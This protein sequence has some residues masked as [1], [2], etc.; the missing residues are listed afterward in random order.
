MKRIARRI[1]GAVSGLVVGYIAAF[2]VF[3]FVTELRP[4]EYHSLLRGSLYSSLGFVAGTALA[5]SLILPPRR[6]WPSILMGLL[7]YNIG[8]LVL[9]ALHLGP[10]YLHL[11]TRLIDFEALIVGLLFVPQVLATVAFHSYYTPHPQWMPS[12]LS[13]FPC[14]DDA[15][16]ALENRNRPGPSSK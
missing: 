15:A 2:I 7:C 5:N 14:E 8:I 12:I 4:F 1:L 6:V 3:A 9:A 16:K 11:G 13:P 10:R